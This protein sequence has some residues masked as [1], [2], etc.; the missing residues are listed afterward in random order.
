MTVFL[1][2][3]KFFVGLNFINSSFSRILSAELSQTMLLEP[4]VDNGRPEV[5]IK[6]DFIV[7]LCFSL[8]FSIFLLKGFQSLLE[9]EPY[10]T[11]IFYLLVLNSF[12]RIK[13]WVK[14]PV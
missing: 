10:D 7:Y 11:S 3:K 4:I 14:F 2:Y 8:D 12:I 9:T 5:S 13:F 1:L 6:A